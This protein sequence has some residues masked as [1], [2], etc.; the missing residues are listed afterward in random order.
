MNARTERWFIVL[1]LLP[2]LAI[3]SVYAEAL[4]ASHA[5][6]HRPI[7][8]L[9]DPKSLVTAPV[10][11]VSTMLVLSVF[12]ATV[13]LAVVVVKNRRSLRTRSRYWVWISIF[14]LAFAFQLWLSHRD[15][16]T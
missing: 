10:H 16:K 6:K 3:A 7:P 5:L 8:S 14:V 1:C 4:L 12:P 2:A 11:F 13:I 9:E 15:P